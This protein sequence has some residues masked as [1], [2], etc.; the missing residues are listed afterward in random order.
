MRHRGAQNPHDIIT[1]NAR[2]HLPGFDNALGGACAQLGKGPAPGAVNARQP[3]N[4]QRQRGQGLPF[5]LG[6]NAGLAAGGAG[7]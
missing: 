5:R 1:M 7:C 4:M 3:E 6:Q 2:K